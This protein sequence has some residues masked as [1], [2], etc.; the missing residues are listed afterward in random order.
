MQITKAPISNIRI[1]QSSNRVSAHVIATF[2][3]QTSDET[4]VVVPPK[5][6]DG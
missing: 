3:D 4:I 1:L 5:A 2:G 6:G